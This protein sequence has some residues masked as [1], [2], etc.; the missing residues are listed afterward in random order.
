MEAACF[1]KGLINICYTTLLLNKSELNPGPVPVLR[2]NQDTHIFREDFMLD[3]HN[4]ADK[5]MGGKKK[6]K[7]K[8]THRRSNIT[9]NIYI[10]IYT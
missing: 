3:P 1:F 8:K 5:R 7:E 4:R 9:I 6:K 2:P 10:Y